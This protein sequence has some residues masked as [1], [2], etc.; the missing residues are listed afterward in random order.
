MRISPNHYATFKLRDRRGGIGAMVETTVRE[1]TRPQIGGG[2]L[3][4]VGTNQIKFSPTQ[5]KH[6]MLNGQD[7]ILFTR[8]QQIIATS[9]HGPDVHYFFHIKAWADPIT[10]RVVRI[11]QHSSESASK[12]GPDFMILTRSNFRY[13]Q[14]PP[15]GVFDWSPPLGAKMYNER[16]ALD[17]MIFHLRHAAAPASP[18]AGP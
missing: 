18:H 8:D 4:A 6:T 16:E 11:E 9:R 15:S 14:P 17:A 1:I 5:Q 13:N 2:L 3:G 12:R 10:R 7:C